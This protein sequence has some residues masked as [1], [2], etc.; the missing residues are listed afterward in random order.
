MAVNFSQRIKFAW[1]WILRF[2]WWVLCFEWGQLFS[3]VLRER[4]IIW[5][6]AAGF[7]LRVKLD[8]DWVLICQ[9]TV[10]CVVVVVFVLRV[11]LG[12]LVLLPGPVL[13]KWFRFTLR[14]ER[15]VERRVRGWLP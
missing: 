10:L 13:F 4:I 14:L 7:V 6:V 9:Y 3:S 8:G 1:S 5:G 2:R 12:L 15:R 11:K